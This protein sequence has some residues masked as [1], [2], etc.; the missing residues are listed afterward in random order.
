M[1]DAEVTGVDTGEKLK[2]MKTIGYDEIIDYKKENFTK[3]GECYDL[4]LDAKTSQPTWTYLKALKPKGKYVTVGGTA[5]NLI[6]FGLT[7]GLISIITGKKFQLLAL[8]PNQG[9]DYINQL[10]AEG[11]IK[12]VIDGPYAFHEIPQLIQYFG[13]GKHTGKVVI[14]LSK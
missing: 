2:N 8:Q 5:G 13:E 4:I 12:A 6:L 14:N 7:A 10:Y 1:Y 11:K 9:L 3:R